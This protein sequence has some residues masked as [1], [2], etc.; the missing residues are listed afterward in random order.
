LG[1][2]VILGIWAI[3]H[4]AENAETALRR[5]IWPDSCNTLFSPNLFSWYMLGFC[6]SS[7]L[8]R[9]V[10]SSLG[11]VFIGSM[12]GRVG[13]CSAV[14]S[15]YPYLFIDWKPVNAAILVQFI[16][17]RHSFSTRIHA[18]LRLLI[19]KTH[20]LKIPGSYIFASLLIYILAFLLPI[21]L[22]SF[23]PDR[24][25]LNLLFSQG[26]PAYIR[27]VLAFIRVS[28]LYWLG[29][30]IVGKLQDKAT[31]VSTSI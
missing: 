15:D 29:Y 5:C 8:S 10:N 11:F 3:L 17:L 31:G 19:K 7:R 6:H 30:R 9:T 21:N 14:W 4:P 28:V 23:M 26:I 25:W 20:P 12:P 1:I 18:S 22:W 2:I 16:T 24:G 13:G 27:S